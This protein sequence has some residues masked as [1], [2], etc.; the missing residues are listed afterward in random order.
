MISTVNL[1]ATYHETLA[2]NLDDYALDAVIARIGKDRKIA[3]ITAGTNSWSAAFMRGLQ[4]SG[5]AIVHVRMKLLEFVE[6]A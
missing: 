4:A 5:P 1:W 6:N 3:E 2:V